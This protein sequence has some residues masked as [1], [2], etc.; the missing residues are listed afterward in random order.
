MP[1]ARIRLEPWGALAYGL[2]PTES[3]R[4]EIVVGQN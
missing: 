2:T 1:Q 3:R 4:V